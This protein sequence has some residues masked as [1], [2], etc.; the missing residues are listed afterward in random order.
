[1]KCKI[2][3]GT[4]MLLLEKSINEWLEENQ[5]IKTVS[6]LQSESSGTESGL[7]AGVLGVTISIFYED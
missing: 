1:M 5:S 3:S 4:Q 7:G 6:I 2:F